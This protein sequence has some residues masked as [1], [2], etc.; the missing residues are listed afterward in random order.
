MGRKTW[1]SLPKK[2]LPN[3]TNVVITKT[4][5]YSKEAHFWTL[6]QTKLVMK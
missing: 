4:P 2:P 6:G 3:R 1:D 5:H